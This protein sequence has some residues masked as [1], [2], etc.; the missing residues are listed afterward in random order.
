MPTAR[1]V[2]FHKTTSLRP[3]SF[4]ACLNAKVLLLPD[5]G[6]NVICARVIKRAKGED[7]NP[8][9]LHNK[10]PL[11]D[12]RENTVEFPDGSTTKHQASAIAENLFTQSDL[13]GHQHVVMKEIC[14]HGTDGHQAIPTSNGFATSKNGNKVPKQTTIGWQ[15]LVQWKH[16]SSDWTNL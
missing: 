6:D 13:E 10:N 11:L 7:G 3:D 9:G 14:D 1:R 16:G 5:S 15:L 4:D 8:L 12:T 2:H